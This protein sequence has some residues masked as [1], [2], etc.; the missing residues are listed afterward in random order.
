MEVEYIAGGK[1][2][3]VTVSAKSEAHTLGNCMRWMLSQNPEVAYVAY[4]VPHPIQ[5]SM[6]LKVTTKTQP[7]LRVVAE[8]CQEVKDVARTLLHAYDAAWEEFEAN[9]Q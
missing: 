8:A 7:A 2:T 5:P 4:T 1:Q 9:D 3:S 6:H